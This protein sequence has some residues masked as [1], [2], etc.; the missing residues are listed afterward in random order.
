MCFSVEREVIQANFV[1][2]AEDE[3]EVLR[4]SASQKFCGGE[5]KMSVFVSHSPHSRDLPPC[6]RSFLSGVFIKS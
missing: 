1:V 5:D 4:V 6:C 2:S 3:I